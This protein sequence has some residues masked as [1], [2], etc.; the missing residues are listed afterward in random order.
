MS[1][2]T[3]V[4]GVSIDATDKIETAYRTG[5]QGRQFATLRVGNALGI[6]VVDASPEV[7]RQLVAG[8]EELAE[9]AE[10]RDAAADVAD[11]VAA[12]DGVRSIGVPYKRGTEAA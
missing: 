2:V 11:Q 5:Y 7:L 4:V 3:G 12:E 8:F 1:R 6:D 10:A 9:W